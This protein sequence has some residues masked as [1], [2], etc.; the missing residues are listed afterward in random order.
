MPLD[1]AGPEQITLIL[2]SLR[3]RFAY[4]LVDLPADWTNWSLSIAASADR[5]LMVTDSSI[6]SLR[7]G[8]RKID[9]LES[10][11]VNRAAIKLIANR[12]ERRLFRT[13]GTDD[14]AEALK[15]DVVATLGEEAGT[16]RAAQDQGVLLGDTSGRNAYVR[17]IDEIARRLSAGEL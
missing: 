6:A 7:Q 1:F 9:L 5:I 3:R 11:G 14:I 4:V 16:L 17:S 2:N 15:A 13:I 12:T 8:R 10:V